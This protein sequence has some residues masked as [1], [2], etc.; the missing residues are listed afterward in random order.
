MCMFR[1][2]IA[3]T[4]LTIT[5]TVCTAAAKEDKPIEL[6]TFRVEGSFSEVRFRARFRYNIPGKALKTLVLTKAPKSW[7]E[8]GIAVGDQ[9]ISI[10][11]TLVDGMS[12]PTVVKL[13]EGKRG[14]PMLFEMR[15]KDGKQTRKMEFTA[16]KDSSNLTIHYP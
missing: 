15:S 3:L 11:G 4:F 6:P 1:L 14:S 7:A 9:L 13:L 10:E 16:I 2:F 8:H 12:L 5:G